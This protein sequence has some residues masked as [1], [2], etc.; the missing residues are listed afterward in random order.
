MKKS[1][2]CKIVQDLLHNYINKETN[3]ETNSFIEIHIRAL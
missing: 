3:E 2:K 1:K